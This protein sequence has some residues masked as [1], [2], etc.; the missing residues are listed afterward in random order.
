MILT[1]ISIA[2]FIMSAI[3]LFR[4]FYHPV[5]PLQKSN[6]GMPDATALYQPIW[7][8]RKRILIYPKTDKRQLWQ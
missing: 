3:A 1:V 2:A 7:D 4:S 5:T 8:S 6:P